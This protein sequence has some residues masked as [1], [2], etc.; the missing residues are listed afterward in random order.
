MPPKLLR[1]GVVDV[2]GVYYVTTPPNVDRSTP[3]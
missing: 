1:K 2:C 3:E